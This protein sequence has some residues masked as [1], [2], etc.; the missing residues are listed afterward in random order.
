MF[1]NLLYEKNIFNIINTIEIDICEEIFKNIKENDPNFYHLKSF[2]K[3]LKENILGKK[4]KTNIK[5]V[6]Q[7]SNQKALLS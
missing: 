4:N 3:A 6:L 5:D 1:Y 2:A 7:F